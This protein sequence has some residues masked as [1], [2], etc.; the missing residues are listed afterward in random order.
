MSKENDSLEEKIDWL[1]WE[2]KNQKIERK[3]ER[4]ISKI[5]GLYNVLFALTTFF[6]GLFVSQYH[7]LSSS[8]S[9]LLFPI[10]GL[11]LSMI[12]SYSIGFLAMVRDSIES[13]IL[14]WGVFLSGLTLSLTLY[15]FLDVAFWTGELLQIFSLLIIQFSFL[16]FFYFLALRFV[17][18]LER[19]F[20]NIVGGDSHGWER[21]KYRVMEK[22]I[23]ASIVNFIGSFLFLSIIANFS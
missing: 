18:F 14:S 13:R 21:M 3:K 7:I 9:Y 11:V 15:F 2:S 16:A 10:I 23:L 12:T 5:D 17:S 8:L 19:K 6:L 20:L 4:I 1:I 22:I